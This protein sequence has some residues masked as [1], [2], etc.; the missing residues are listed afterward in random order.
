MHAK[1][2]K[3]AIEENSRLSFLSVRRGFWRFAGFNRN[4]GPISLLDKHFYMV[5]FTGILPGALRFQGYV[6]GNHHHGGV[7]IPAQLRH[8]MP[9]IGSYP[10][11]I[12][13]KRCG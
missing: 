3:K 7:K 12:G 10:E 1:V 6:F 4:E 11:N 13:R 5:R 2:E 8:I 9:G